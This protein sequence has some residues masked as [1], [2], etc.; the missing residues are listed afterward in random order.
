M[1]EHQKGRGGPPPELLNAPTKQE[2]LQKLFDVWAPR[3]QTETIPLAQALNRVLAEDLRARYNIPVVR[4]SSMDG[5]AIAYESIKDGLPD[6]ARWQL[7]REFVRADTGDDFPDQYDT[8]IQIE[9]VTMLPEGGL[10]FQEGIEIRPGQNVRPCGSTLR[11][12]KL[13]VKK[14]TRLGV[15]DL[16]ALGSGGYSQIPVARRPRVAFLPT[17]SELVPIGSELKRGQNFE[18]NSLVAANMLEEMGAE[19]Q[20]CPLIPDDYNILKEQITRLCGENDLVIVNAGT[21]KGSED[22]CPHVLEEIGQVLFHGVRAVPGRPMCVALYQGTPVVNLSGPSLAAF[23][24]LEWA[25][26]PIVAR[27]LGVPPVRRETVEA[28]LDKPLNAPG[29]MSACM[30]LALTEDG[31]GN[32]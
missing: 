20:I 2:A 6:T 25:V 13:L 21:S 19:P 1:H 16:A 8:V 23:Y 30:K 9:Q 17:G 26:K 5:V 14:G 18:T 11:E 27:A 12:G 28:R 31:E 22:Y 32:L 4:A 10:R 7:G 24:G 29:F 15:L 3:Q